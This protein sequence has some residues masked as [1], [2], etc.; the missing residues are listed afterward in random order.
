MAK[1]KERQEERLL[2]DEKFIAHT[3]DF[4]ARHAAKIAVAF[5]I[6]LCVII[7]VVV[8]QHAS[9]SQEKEVGDYLE[10]HL[11]EPLKLDDPPLYSMP[12]PE[13]E[14]SKPV[15]LN[16][17]EI[18]EKV[19]G[20]HS[21]PYVLAVL[22]RH[23]FEK[24]GEASWARA[25]RIAT[26]LRDDYPDI[27]IYQQMAMTILSKIKEQRTWEKPEPRALGPEAPETGEPAE[28][29]ETGE[30][31]EKA[32]TGESAEK[33]ETGEPAEKAETGEPAEKAET[34]EPA[35]KAET[36][37]PAEKAETGEPAE[38]AE[39]GE[40]APGGDPASG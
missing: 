17:E 8:S 2:A 14:G 1:S 22:A 23:F 18:L 40:P 20:S 7:G 5:V 19:Q 32:E 27:Q 34:G 15:D 3:G 29:A 31:A 37:E 11:F 21:R 16:V 25:E 30:S 36:G 10:E 24:G 33:A 9:R 4:L 39:T 12:T 6:I 13:D 35:E 26:T 28:K 38:K